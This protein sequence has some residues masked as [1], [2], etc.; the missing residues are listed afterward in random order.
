MSYILDALERSEHERK[1]GEL[2]SFRKDQNLLYMRKERKSPWLVLLVLVLLLNALVFLYIHFSNS[3]D[4]V[5]VQADDS[6]ERGMGSGARN[7]LLSVT[8]PDTKSTVELALSNED[9]LPLSVDSSTT[10]QRES[11][12]S[13]LVEPKLVAESAI[14]PQ[15]KDD[16]VIEGSNTEVVQT[17]RGEQGLDLESAAATGEALLPVVESSTVSAGEPSAVSVEKP[18]TDPF[19]E[20]FELIEPKSKRLSQSQSASAAIVS[21]ARVV[22]SDVPLDAAPVQSSELANVEDQGVESES[23]DPYE[24]VL[25]LEELDQRTRPKVSKLTFNSHIYSSAP[26]ARRVMINNIYLREG[27]AFQGMTLLSIGE[28]HVVFEKDGQQFKIAAMR[29]WMG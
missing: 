1:Q 27:Q 12:S 11:R 8:V 18:S 2:P 23:I 15:T 7:N 17:A 28:Q 3:A 24:D 6:I 14:I 19:E 25:Y 20:Q 22:V 29:D 9:T 4:N 13:A 5:T 26:S 21:D 10:Q 16:A